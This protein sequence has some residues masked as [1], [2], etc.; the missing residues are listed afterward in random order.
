M[1]TVLDIKLLYSE[2]ETSEAF[3]RAGDGAE[4]TFESEFLHRGQDPEQLVDSADVVIY[5]LEGH[6]EADLQLLHQF[7]VAHPEIEVFV[8][9]DNADME[10]MRR[11]MRAGVRDTLALPLDE[12]EYRKIMS[13]LLDRKRETMDEARGKVIAFMN[14]KGGSGATTLAVN[15]A[16]EVASRHDLKVAI[17]DFDIQFGDVALFLDMPAK[18]TVMEALSQ[19]SRLDG[20]ML[21]AVLQK[22]ASGLA[23]LPSPG[24]LSR[25]SDITAKEVRR[26]VDVACDTHDIVILDIPRL[27]ND[28]TE[29]LL[30]ISDHFML[31]IENGLTTVRDAKTILDQMPTFNASPDKVDVL[32]NRAEAK[33]GSVNEKQITD[34]LKVEHIVRL[35]NDYTAAI[36]AQDRGQPLSSVAPTSKLTK[37]IRHMAET[38]AA[39]VSPGAT[40]KPGLF[41]RIFT[42]QKAGA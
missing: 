35:H 3:R 2:Q 11:L 17:I 32:L 5:E 23:V 21:D 20:T 26:L 8:T 4:W 14:A 9:Y 28:W 40:R 30:R 13:E 42:G 38:V 34:A 24:G 36:T 29:E 10:I 33:H 22:H 41:K 18:S 19:A 31:V 1:T 37:D 6:S 27:F 7:I 12:D 16:H 25:V 15:L 39:E